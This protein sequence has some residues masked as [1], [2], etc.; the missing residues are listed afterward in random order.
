MKPKRG[1][2]NR[3]FS[4]QETLG[5]VGVI[6]IIAGLYAPLLRLDTSDFSGIEIRLRGDL[7]ML[8][9]SHQ[10]TLVYMG[11]ASVALYLAAKSWYRGLWMVG[12]TT[13]LLTF[14][15]IYATRKVILESRD[16]V[17]FE[18]PIVER[19]TDFLLDGVTMQWGWALF[20]GGAL[21]FIAAGIM[22]EEG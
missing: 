14:Y 5:I 16:V 4:H 9:L 22:R 3:R 8:D 10:G 19:V 2:P 12:I 6:F 17:L 15:S 20:F 18:N 11:L 21:S 7:N 13:L 1:L